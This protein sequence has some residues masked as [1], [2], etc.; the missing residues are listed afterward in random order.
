MRTPLLVR[1]LANSGLPI[2]EVRV[3]DVDRDRLDLISPLIER[4][5]G[6]KVVTS[7]TVAECVTGADFVIASIRPGGI[8]RRAA[9]EK[10]ALDHGVIGQETVGCR[11]AGPWPS[12]PSRPWWSTR[13]RWPG[14]RRTP[15]W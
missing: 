15:G 12:P 6:V 7:P 1:G 11:A 10:I 13:R 14:T 8:E 4:V 2:R 5:A 9:Y 3:F